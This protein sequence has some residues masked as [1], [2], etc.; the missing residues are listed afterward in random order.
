MYPV[1]HVTSKEGIW[2]KTAKL[3][4]LN[5]GRGGAGL[6]GTLFLKMNVNDKNFI[7]VVNFYRSV[8]SVA[9]QLL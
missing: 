5:T 8:S 4:G 7:F 1:F 3:D 2:T 9:P 6:V